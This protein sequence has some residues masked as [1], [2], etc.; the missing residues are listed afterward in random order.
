MNWSKFIKVLE[1]DSHILKLR[2][3]FNLKSY[4]IKQIKKYYFVI[5]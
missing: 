1:M 3:N 2:L 5:K 4:S